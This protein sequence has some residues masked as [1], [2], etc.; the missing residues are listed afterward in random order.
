MDKR[1][2]EIIAGIPFPELKRH[3][4][5]RLILCE[6]Q[7]DQYLS[8]LMSTD[9]KQTREFL[10]ISDDI[11]WELEKRKCD[12]GLRSWAYTF[13][14]FQ[15]IEKSTGNV[16]GQ[17]GYHTHNLRHAKAEVGYALFDQKYS[18][19]GLMQEAF[20]FVLEFGFNTMNLF[21]VEA[22]TS[23]TNE[24]S[25]KILTNSGFREEG[26]MVG[27]YLRE[28]IAEDSV[29]YGLLRDEWKTKNAESYN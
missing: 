18:G 22:M 25:K 12:F 21:R 5:E 17:I 9:E 29:M 27:N 14:Y 7:P 28:G 26:Y 24:A 20:R 3:N 2:D 13:V 15:M 1:L 23:P 10:Q 8:M 6:I 19:K 16:I 4:T 11:K